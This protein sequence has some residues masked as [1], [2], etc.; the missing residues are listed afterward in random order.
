MFLFWGG[1]QDGNQGL[2]IGGAHS[3]PSDEVRI[4]RRRQTG[5]DVGTLAGCGDSIVN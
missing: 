5:C 3:R 1:N 2:E 4:V